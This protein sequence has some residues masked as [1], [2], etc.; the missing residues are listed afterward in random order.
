MTK[1][2]RDQR[3]E[4][5]ID[6]ALEIVRTEGADALTLATLAARAGVSRPVA[7]E[8]FTTRPGLLLAAFQRLE[9]RYVEQLRGA[10]SSPPSN[11]LAVAEVMSRAYFN[12]HADLGAEGPAISAALKGSDEMAAQQRA[13]VGEYVEIMLKALR[14]HSRLTD[15]Q[16]SLR[17]IGILGAAEAMANETQVGKTTLDDAIAALTTMIASAA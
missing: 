16:L 15:E 11:L 6:Q 2:P 10:L 12:C 7:Y 17:C 14:P 1:L 8:H 9:D 3:R 4:L 5:L 13:M